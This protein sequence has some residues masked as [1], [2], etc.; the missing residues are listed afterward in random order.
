MMLILQISIHLDTI[1]L[2]ILLCN[3]KHFCEGEILFV[4]A[5]GS[6]IKPPYT[7]NKNNQYHLITL[8]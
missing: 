8:S 3:K 6:Y 2:D 7:A 4:E 5:K 1:L